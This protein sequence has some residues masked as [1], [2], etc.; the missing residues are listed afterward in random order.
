M[1]RRPRPGRRI[2]ARTRSTRRRAARPARWLAGLG[3]QDAA[4]A[5]RSRSDRG[6]TVAR[7]SDA[8]VVAPEQDAAAL[9]SMQQILDMA[10]Q[11]FYA[12]PSKITGGRTAHTAALIMD[13]VQ[14]LLLPEYRHADPRLPVPLTG[15]ASV[16]VPGVPAT[17]A[18]VDAANKKRAASNFGNSA[19]PPATLT[20]SSTSYRSHPSP[21]RSRPRADPRHQLAQYGPFYEFHIEPSTT[22]TDDVLAR[23]CINATGDALVNGRLRFA[24]DDATGPLATGNVRLAISRSSTRIEPLT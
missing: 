24:H 7:Q 5:V 2:R 11:D 8:G 17:V 13:L 9:G 22:F 16:V 6:T 1:F 20:T 12:N 21:P 19:L 23:A 14:G 18:V 15:V 10:F 4:A 3:G